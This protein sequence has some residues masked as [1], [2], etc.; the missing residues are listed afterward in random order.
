MKPTNNDN[1]TPAPRTIKIGK[2]SVGLIGLE[3]ALNEAVAQGLKADEA[4][5]HIYKRVSKANYVPSSAKDLYM[6]ALRKEYLRRTGQEVE[7]DDTL[8]IRVLGTGCI[9]CNELSN[10]LIEVLQ[11]L[12]LAA[13]MESI[14][15]LDEIWRFGVTKT[16]ALIINNKVKVAGRMP[17]LFEVEVWVKE[18]AGL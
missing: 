7:G 2:A 18:E 3:P 17:A 9:V 11:K 10:M 13:D 14:H 15:D 1:D 12:D 8:T 4:V 6:D 5:E 16:P